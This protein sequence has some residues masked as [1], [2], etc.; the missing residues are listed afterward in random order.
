MNNKIERLESFF[1]TE[2]QSAELQELKKSLNNMYSVF[3][4]YSKPS[5]LR[6]AS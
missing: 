2:H 6:F 1:D 5:S 3:S 4:V